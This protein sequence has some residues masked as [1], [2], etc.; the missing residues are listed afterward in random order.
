MVT[1]RGKAAWEEKFSPG[2]HRAQPVLPSAALANSDPNSLLQGPACS[3]SPTQRPLQTCQLPPS[4]PS[5]SSWCCSRWA[6]TARWV[7]AGESLGAQPDPLGH[8]RSTNTNT[9][10]A[11]GLAARLAAPG[12]FWEAAAVTPIFIWIGLNVMGWF[13]SVMLWQFIRPRNTSKALDSH[14]RGWMQPSRLLSCL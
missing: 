12:A 2:R 7:P 5:S 13:V 10:T 4:L 14:T 11:A 9:G 1:A 8:H 3:S 6:W